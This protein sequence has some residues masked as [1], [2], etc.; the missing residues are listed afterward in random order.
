MSYDEVLKKRIDILCIKQNEQEC[1]REFYQRL[2]D[3]R[4]EHRT[5]LSQARENY[6]ELFETIVT[7]EEN[8]IIGYVLGLKLDIREYLR[9]PCEYKNLKEAAQHA[10]R[11]EHHL[12]R[13]KLTAIIECDE[14]IYV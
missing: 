14:A 8:A 10:M 2:R 4:N 13:L 5:V 11:I 1:A 7:T 6:K 9:A 12:K 3:L